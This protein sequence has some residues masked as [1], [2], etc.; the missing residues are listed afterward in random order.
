MRAVALGCGRFARRGHQG[1]VAAAARRAPRRARPS[2]FT[3]VEVLVA[4][5]LGALLLGLVGA[6]LAGGRRHGAATETTVDA[7]ATLRLAAELL[8]EELRLTGA[9]PWPTPA[10]VPDVPDVEGWLAAPL[11]LVVSATGSVVGARYVDHRLADGP[12]ARDL[13]FEAAPDGAGEPQLYRRQAGSPR[14][15]LVAGI[16]RLAVLEVV[17]ASG[18][19]LSP[20]AAGGHEVA[21][22]LIELGVGPVSALVV[23]ELPTK[24][25]AE[26]VVR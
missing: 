16:D 24:P 5:A 15:P 1:A 11:T 8:R 26:V 18:V 25:L 4:L 14:Q 9:A 20:Q 13:T 17:T 7:A 2:G 19:G 6:L 12:V 23:V 3:L 21:A 22:L 10:A